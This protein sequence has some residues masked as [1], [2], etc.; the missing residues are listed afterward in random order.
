MRLTRPP[1]S[2]LLFNARTSLATC[3]DDLAAETVAQPRRT[4]LGAKGVN[5]TDTRDE[6]VMHVV[7]KL[8]ERLLQIGVLANLRTDR[9]HLARRR[10]DEVSM[11][12]NRVIKH[13]RWIS[14]ARADKPDQHE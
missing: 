13:P 12:R 2:Q 4:V 6:R 10:H 14:E 1:P 11:R 3:G 7:V 5:H 8:V 9:A